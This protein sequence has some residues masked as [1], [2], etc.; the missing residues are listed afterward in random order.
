MTVRLLLLLS[1]LLAIPAQAQR[2]AVMEN[3]ATT[4]NSIF[5]SSTATRVGI[6]TASPCST[7]TLHVAGSASVTT[8]F[9]VDAGTA[10]IGASYSPN[11]ATDGR[12]VVIQGS[13][14]STI[15]DH[16]VIGVTDDGGPV[17]SRTQVGVGY[18]GTLATHKYPVVYGTR[19]ISSSGQGTA[20]FFVANREDTNGTSTPVEHLV[21]L[22]SG[23]VGI[24]DTSPDAQLEIVSRSGPT[25]YTVLVSSQND[26][27]VLF[28]VD[29]SGNALALS[30]VTA[31]AFFGNGSG[32]TGLSSSEANT[33]TSSKTFTSDVLGKS[34]ITA[35]AFF[36]NGSALTGLAGEANTYA[37]SKTFT[38]NV[39]MNASATASGFFGNGSALTGLP[40]AQTTVTYNLTGATTETTTFKVCYASGTLTTNGSSLIQVHYSGSI[41]NSGAAGTYCILN[42]M[43]DGAF[44]SPYTSTVG[45]GASVNGAAGGFGNAT[46]T[47][48]FP[49]PSA[50]SHSWCLS[51][52]SPFGTTCT[53]TYAS[54]HG[55]EFGVTELR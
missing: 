14:S 18:H 49:A 2:R 4:G 22:P 16:I 21:V 50:G 51:M 29:G 45:M 20:A 24:N 36:G 6:G 42:I 25:A 10:V 9:K 52:I 41:T 34:S 15:G 13:P 39:L 28:S 54:A 55:N 1:S 37:S 8:D 7:C 23:E 40:V 3:L 12:L 33:Y 26:S 30:S 35:S 38:T 11:V 44:I 32:L 31:N 43:Q 48:I 27:T 19:L 53:F 17:G 5:I 47:R 46:M